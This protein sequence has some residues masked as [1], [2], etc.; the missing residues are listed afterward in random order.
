M[1]LILQGKGFPTTFPVISATS[2]VVPHNVSSFLVY[3]SSHPVSCF[4]SKIGEIDFDEPVNI[5][6]QLH[7][8]C[9]DKDNIFPDFQFQSFS[10]SACAWGGCAPNQNRF[11]SLGEKDLWNPVKWLER[12]SLIWRTEERGFLR[13]HPKRQWWPLSKHPALAD[14]FPLVF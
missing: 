7:L 8:Q 14:I 11:V 2:M 12:L 4:S 9:G 6:Y 5:H 3:F 1:P 13:F 10:R